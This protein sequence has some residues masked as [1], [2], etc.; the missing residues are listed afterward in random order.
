M[1]EHILGLITIAVAINKGHNMF[2]FF[3]VPGADRLDTILVDMID[4]SVLGLV[5]E[6][7]T[8]DDRLYDLQVQIRG[9]A[10]ISA[11]WL[12]PVR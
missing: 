9:L 11:S 1:D 4:G 3:W 8:F 5:E 12:D 7:E 6:R 2:S 10:L